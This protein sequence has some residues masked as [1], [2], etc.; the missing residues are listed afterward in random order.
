M[1]ALEGAAFQRAVSDFT[2]RPN[3]AEPIRAM[4]ELACEA[5]CPTV[6]A[7]AAKWLKANCNILVATDEQETRHATPAKAANLL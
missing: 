4:M 2:A 6:R 5:Q 3:A 7:W 1:R